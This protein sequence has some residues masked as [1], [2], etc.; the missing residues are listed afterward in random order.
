MHEHDP[1]SAL[2]PSTALP[3]WW[4]GSGALERVVADLIAHEFRA[5]RPRTALPAPPWPLDLALCERGLG[6]D[7][8]D[9]LAVAGALSELLQ[10]HESGIEDYLLTRR[11]FGDWLQV[12]RAGLAR[13]DRALTFRTSGSTGLPKPCPHPLVRLEAEAEFWGDLFAGRRRVLAAVPA[14]HIYGLI[15]TVLLPRH[16]GE[17]AVLDLRGH[18]PAALRRLLRP[19]DLVVGHPVWWSA[20]ARGLPEGVPVDV[21]G[22][23]ST[24]PCPE[25]TA[26][27]VLAAGFARLVQVYGSSE[28][29][30][31]GWRE[32]PEAPSALLPGWRR[33]T[34]G[35]VRGEASI[36]PPDRLD[37]EDAC[38]FRVLGRHDGAVQVGGV[39]VHPERVAAVLREHPQVVE[40]TVRLMRPE[41]GDRLKA[42]VV[43]RQGGTGEEALRAILV[44][45]VEARLPPPERPRAF[46]FGPA[47]PLSPAGKAA[48]W[49]AL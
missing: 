24:A 44:A 30:G 5:L 28:T 41:E 8:L 12:A 46:A 7:S 16:F 9:L 1:P 49:P 40:A 37:W 15:F 3:P 36:P 42:F 22:V 19:G 25:A 14:H 39:N 45:H 32:A 35:L 13:H 10:L 17:D 29:A 11:G 21:V 23:T 4:H 43:P 34:A 47:L 31:I 26:R 48:D 38:R 2:T 18:S 27:A 20:V 6:L 33:G